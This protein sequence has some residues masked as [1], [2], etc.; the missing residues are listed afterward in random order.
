MSIALNP[1]PRRLHDSDALNDTL[2]MPLDAQAGT[3]SPGMRSDELPSSTR[4]GALADVAAATRG[5]RHAW[6]RALSGWW[7]PGAAVPRTSAA[8]RSAEG[9]HAFERNYFAPSA[10]APLH[11]VAGRQLDG[12]Q[13]ADGQRR[14]APSGSTSTHTLSAR[15]LDGFQVWLDGEPVCDL[16]QGKASALLQVLLLQRRRPISRKRLCAMFWPDADAASARN[17]LNVT[18]HRLR[19]ALGKVNL[20]RHSEAGYQIWVPGEV[21]LDVEHFNFNA[22]I[23]RAEELSGNTATAIHW[24]EAAVALYHADLQDSLDHEPALAPDSQLLRDRLNEVLDH[25]AC[26]REQVG[27]LHGCVRTT[28][29][30]LAQDE[31]NEGA[32]Q[33]LMRCYARLG[34]PQLAERQY[35]ACV[36]TLRLQLGLHPR[37]DTTALCR[38][39]ARREMV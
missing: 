33:R 10:P 31:C 26:L 15:M 17:S 23:G 7:V 22:D 28:L 14:A 3:R 9:Q 35:R 37:A 18:L 36:N 16:P 29:R 6:D 20:L 4:R 12:Q 11:E 34:Q 27:D 39:I 38:R 25:L 8:Q 24:Y 32:H 21:W 19:R 30:H 13:P 5:L 2:L 1:S